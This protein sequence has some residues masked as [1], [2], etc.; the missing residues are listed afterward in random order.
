MK[1]TEEII[2]GLVN[3]VLSK[4]FDESTESP[5]FHHEL[6]REA[7]SNHQ[8]VAIAAPRGHA[9]STAGTLAYGLAEVLFRASRYV[10]IVSDT[11]AQATMFV[12]AMAQELTEN[13]D[14]I[15]LFGIKKNDKG[16]VQFLKS[17]EADIIV[18][19]NDGHTFRIMGKGAEQKLRGMLWNGLRP[20]LVLIDDLENDELVLNKE[21]R[22]KLKRWFRGALIPMLAKKGKLRYWGTI[23]HMDSVLENLMPKE[24]DKYTVDTGLKV[25]STNPRK[26]MWRS[27]KYRAHN[28]DFSKILWPAR[29]PKEFFKTRMEEF[30]AAGMMDLYSQEYLNNPIDE[31]VAYFKRS[32]FLPFRDGDKEKTLHYYITLDPAVSQEARSDYTVFAIAGVDEDRNILAKQVIRERLDAKE[33]VDLLLALQRTYEPEAIGIEKMMVSQAFGPF[34]REEMIRQNTFPSIV[35]LTHGG[36]DKM[37]RARNIQARMRAK[38]CRFD[39]SADWYPVF[40][41]ELLKFPRGIK[42]DQVDAWA[43]MGM[44]LDKMIEAPTKEEIEEEEY[45]DELRESGLAFSGRSAITGY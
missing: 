28:D 1:L 18:E 19:C 32:D 34:L 2:S 9:K 37:Q 17:T 5:E 15:E 40:E 3:S 27:I 45:L 25:Y 42:D 6:W 12:Q 43:Y 33:I 10:L 4:R 8:F 14:L 23:L 22:D 44:L 39:K 24:F 38:T 29:Y 13:E 30:S 41:D 31:S 35:E 36:K 21:R 11:E 26:Q 16:L 7:C 20:D